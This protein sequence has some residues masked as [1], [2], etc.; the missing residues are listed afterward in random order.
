MLEDKRRMKLTDEDGGDND[1]RRP[2]KAEPGRFLKNLKT[3]GIPVMYFDR[4]AELDEMAECD[5][6]G[7]LLDPEQAARDYSALSAEEKVNQA[8]RTVALIRSKDD[9]IMFAAGHNMKFADESVP[10]KDL[11]VSFIDQLAQTLGVKAEPEAPA[12]T[13]PPEPKKTEEPA[14]AE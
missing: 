4:L 10:L 2:S 14:A 12:E 6:D 3:G 11:K 1:A 7:N 9:M 8:R 5:K 13:P